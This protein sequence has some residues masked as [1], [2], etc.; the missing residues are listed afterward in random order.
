MSDSETSCDPPSTITIASL[1][2]ATTMFISV[3]SS[4]LFVGLQTNSPPTLPT[5]TAASGP[6]K[7]TSETTSAADAAVTDN[8]S[9]S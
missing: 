7:G 2:P 9:G 1:V 4:W 8:T 3:S 5:L 6:S